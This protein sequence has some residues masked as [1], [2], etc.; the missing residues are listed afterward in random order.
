MTNKWKKNGK[1]WIK[2][3]VATNEESTNVVSVSVTDEHRSNS[4]EFKN[5]LDPIIG[6]VTKVDGDKGYDGRENFNY[7]ANNN[8]TPIILQ[9]KNARTR[10]KGSP[11][12]AKVVREINKMGVENW[13]ESVEYCKR[14]RGEI[15]FSALKRVMGEVIR[16]KKTIYQFQEAVMKI[17][18]YFLLRK[19][20][21]VS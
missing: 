10:A 9:R 16:A 18:C 5:V 4:K 13:K 19:N 14:R 11:A 20:T 1:G 3:Y 21:V 7:L 17:F 8:V 6:K 12:R 2:I 15:F